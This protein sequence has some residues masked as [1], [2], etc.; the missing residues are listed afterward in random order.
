MLGA[1]GCGF[2]LAIYWYIREGK[3]SEQE[4]LTPL[5]KWLQER[6]QAASTIERQ[7]LVRGDKWYLRRMEQWDAKNAFELMVGPSRAPELVDSYRAANASHLDQVDGV[8]PPHDLREHER[9]YR[10]RLD[11]LERTFKGLRKGLTGTRG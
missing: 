3:E 6:I 5:E 8:G 7:R 10:R 9:Y 11:W 1:G 2:V 4:P